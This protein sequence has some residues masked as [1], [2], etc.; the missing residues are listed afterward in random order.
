MVIDPVEAEH[1]RARADLPRARAGDCR[2]PDGFVRQV[3]RFFALS[4]AHR[5]RCAAAILA[6]AAADS[7]RRGLPARPG[8]PGPRRLPIW[9]LLLNPSS[10]EIA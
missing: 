7:F 8:R 2:N 6:R 5:A 1:H 4:F 3:F 9:S 10:V